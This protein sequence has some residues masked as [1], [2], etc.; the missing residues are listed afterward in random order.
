MGVLA[1]VKKLGFKNV[2]QVCKVLNIERSTL[3]KAQKNDVTRFNDMLIGAK[4]KL[5]L[6]EIDFYRECADQVGITFQEWFDKKD[7]F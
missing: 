4:Q 7:E 2:D 6:A 5:T 3:Y 1:Q